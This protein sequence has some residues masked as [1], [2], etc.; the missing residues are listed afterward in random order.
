MTLSKTYRVD[1]SLNLIFY[2]IRDQSE[3]RFS[4]RD[5]RKYCLRW[6]HLYTGSPRLYEDEVTYMTDVI[7]NVKSRV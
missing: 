3:L 1:F 6:E 5:T 2:V 7:L 4:V